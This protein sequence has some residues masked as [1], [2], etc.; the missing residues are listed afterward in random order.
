MKKIL[1]AIESITNTLSA[2]LAKANYDPMVEIVPMY[3]HIGIITEIEEAAKGGSPYDAV[4]LPMQTLSGRFDTDLVVY[5]NEMYDV[6]IIQV[7]PRSVR[8]SDQAT[9]LYMAGLYN[10]VFADAN[11]DLT[12]LVAQR[13]SSPRKRSDVPL[14][15]GLH[16]TRGGREL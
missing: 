16:I 5:L 10:C 7:F 9:A 1:C 11:A 13:L 2:A 4:V 8:G 6:D 14:A 3:S 12:T 15:Y